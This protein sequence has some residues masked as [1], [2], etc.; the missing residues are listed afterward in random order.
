VTR[1]PQKRG[2]QDTDEKS[3]SNEKETNMTH[4]LALLLPLALL[5]TGTPASASGPAG[6]E[7]RIPISV[8]SK[9]FEP[10]S[11][12]VKAG[13]P[14]VLVVTRTTDRTCVKEFVIADRKIRSALPFNRAVEIRFTPVKAGTVRF[15]CGMDMVAGKLVVE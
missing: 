3:H 1:T 9:G 7:Q 2:F 8:T 6:A 14:V 12:P 5:T 15:A 13:Q 4:I 10:A 11:I